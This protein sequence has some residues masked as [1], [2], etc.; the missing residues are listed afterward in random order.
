MD[1]RR[2]AL[3]EQRV[4]FL[5]ARVPKD[6]DLLR[7]WFMA[8]AAALKEA[9]RT[10]VVTA[11]GIIGHLPVSDDPN[12]KRLVDDARKLIREWAASTG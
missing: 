8:T 5:E 4:V 12:E 1:E 6:F 2:L 3:L 10:G 9:I 7:M 11:D